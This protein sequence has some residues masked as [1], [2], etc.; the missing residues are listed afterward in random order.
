MA[1]YSVLKMSSAYY[2]CCIYTN[3]LQNTF[4]GEA[5]KMNPDQTVGQSDL[6]PYCLQ[7]RLQTYIK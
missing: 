3:V 5:N 6:G 4:F 2:C 1:I 7:Y